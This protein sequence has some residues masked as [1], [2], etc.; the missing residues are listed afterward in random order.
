MDP[1]FITRDE[2]S[3]TVKELV[4]SDSTHFRSNGEGKSYEKNLYYYPNFSE[5]LNKVAE[6]KMDLKDYSNLK[7]Y[8]KE[9]KS[10]SNQIKNYTDGIRSTIWCC[11]S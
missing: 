6:L 11:Y 10:I 9:F 7:D 4:Q 5:A 3:F 2:Y 8:I 1:F